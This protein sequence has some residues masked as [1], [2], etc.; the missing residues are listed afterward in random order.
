M[1]SF[2]THHAFNVSFGVEPVHI[3]FVV[4]PEWVASL[5]EVACYASSHFESFVEES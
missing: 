1:K 4:E 3:F 5:D 2:E